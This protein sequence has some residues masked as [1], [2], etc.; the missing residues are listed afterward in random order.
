M[1]SPT[2]SA[3]KQS[4]DLE[5]WYLRLKISAKVLHIQTWRQMHV[6]NTSKKISLNTENIIYKCQ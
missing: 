1:R 2:V 3:I 5:L 6:M 4:R